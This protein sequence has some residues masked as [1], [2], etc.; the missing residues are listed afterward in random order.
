M[1]PN[2]WQAMTWT[3]AERV[4]YHIYKSSGLIVLAYYNI[5]EAFIYIFPQSSVL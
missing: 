5:S 2:R 1:T 3:D 4:H